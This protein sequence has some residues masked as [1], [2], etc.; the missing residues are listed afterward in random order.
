MNQTHGG[1]VE[2]DLLTGLCLGLVW[3]TCPKVKN[4]RQRNFLDKFLYGKVSWGCIT[5]G[6]AQTSYDK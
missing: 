3:K 6:V 4:R 5:I 1:D 2:F